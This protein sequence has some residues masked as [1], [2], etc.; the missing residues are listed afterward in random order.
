MFP[1]S[2]VNLSINRNF[3]TLCFRS[4][5]TLHTTA[6]II[7]NISK[8]AFGKLADMGVSFAVV[9]KIE[10]LGSRSGAV[11]KTVIIKDCGEIIK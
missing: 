6:Q 2:M 11:S 8:Y 7:S 9:K 10:K 1:T 3:A 4:L 5:K